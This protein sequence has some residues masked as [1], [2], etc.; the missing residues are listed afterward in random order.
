[1]EA[2]KFSLTV[3]APSG[4]VELKVTRS[5]IHENQESMRVI[6][7]IT[8]QGKTNSYQ[9]DSTEESLMLFARSLP[10]NWTI[11]S[12]LSCRFGHFCPTGD[13]DNE[14]FCVPDFEPKNKSDLWCVTEDEIERKNRSRTLFDCCQRYKQ[15]SEDYFTYSDYLYKISPKE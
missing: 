6:L 4:D 2:N 10:V 11:K 12:C 9:S 13:Y 3:A 15:Q 14:L 8:F 1:M 5:V 7:S